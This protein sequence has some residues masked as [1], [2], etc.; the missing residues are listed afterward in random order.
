MTGEANWDVWRVVLPVC[1][2]GHLLPLLAAGR[3]GGSSRL[4]LE[5]ADDI[6][7]EAATVAKY[8]T[9]VG[10]GV[11]LAVG[12]RGTSATGTVPVPNCLVF[13]LHVVEQWARSEVAVIT[14]DR[15]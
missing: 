1:L 7:F 10:M 15:T 12:E 13:S 3:S 11:V 5:Y 14:A 4:V 9:R 6:R 2:L 8:D